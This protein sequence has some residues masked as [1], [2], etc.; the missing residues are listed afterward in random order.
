MLSA[1]SQKAPNQA[2]TLQRET[3]KKTVVGYAVE[4]LPEI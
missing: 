4:S 2:N 1:F 3:N